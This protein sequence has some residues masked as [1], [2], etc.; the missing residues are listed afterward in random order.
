MADSPLAKLRA[1]LCRKSEVAPARVPKRGE[2]AYYQTL[3]FLNAVLPVLKPILAARPGLA[4]GFKGVT[5]VVQVS[6]LTPRGTSIDGRP[7]RLATHLVIDDGEFS[8]S[9]GAHPAPNLEL[10]FCSIEKLNAFFTGG[11]ALPKLRGAA[12]N[13]VLL[14][15]TVKAL[16]AMAS[17]LG[18]TEP[19]ED[20]EEQALLTQCMFYL[21]TSGISQLNRAGHPRVLKWS[22]WQPDR[23]YQLEVVGHGDL[24][25]N[26]RVKGGRTR[27]ARGRCSRSRPFF[28]MTFDSPRSALGILLEV[29]DMVESTLTSKIVM[30]G[31]PEYGA[32]LG[33]LMQLV[34]DYAK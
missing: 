28:A 32:E 25:A 4:T 10:E 1:L 34:G 22:G 29:D 14:V 12:G 23:I 19:P 21:L 16:L 24:A 27:A 30:Q 33:V 20:G 15:S 2:E 13:P 11:I 31:A 17:L 5:A 6:A 8:V 18:A 26:L 9:L 7:K 3:I